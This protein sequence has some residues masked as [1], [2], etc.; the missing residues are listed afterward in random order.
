M[1][2]QFGVERGIGANTMGYPAFCNNDPPKD[3]N[4]MR[5]PYDGLP[6]YCAACGE[7]MSDSVECGS[8][9]CCMETKQAAEARQRRRRPMTT[10]KPLAEQG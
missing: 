8:P 3:G 1:K 4:L 6:Y 7:R 10:D 2:D 5:D 9:Y